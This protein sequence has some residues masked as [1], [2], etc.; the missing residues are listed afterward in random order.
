[1]PAVLLKLEPSP[2]DRAHAVRFGFGAGVDP[3][4]HAAFEA[5]FG[6]PLV[7]VWGMTEAGGAA[8]TTTGTG[9]RHVGKR[10]IGRLKPEAEYRVVGDATQRR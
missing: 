7:E 10:C 2:D 9:A 1:M 5:R 8:V 6:F 3:D 4:H